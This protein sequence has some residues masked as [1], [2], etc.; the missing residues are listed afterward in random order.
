MS[1][2]YHVEY[3][4]TVPKVAIG[5]SLFEGRKYIRPVLTVF[6]RNA[7]LNWECEIACKSLNDSIKD[8][9]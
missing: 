9:E 7:D 1:K 8:K 2:I 4:M 3:Y 6:E 5:I